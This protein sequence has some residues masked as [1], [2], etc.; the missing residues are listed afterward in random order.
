MH[1]QFFG[2]YFGVHGCGSG[3]KPSLLGVRIMGVHV[4][5]S[6]LSRSGNSCVDV[7]PPRGVSIV[8]RGPVARHVKAVLEVGSGLGPWRGVEGPI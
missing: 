6:R 2:M 4:R 5:G 1:T 7:Y 3:G 8:Y